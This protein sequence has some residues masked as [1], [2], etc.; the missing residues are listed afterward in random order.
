MSYILEAL[1]KSEQDRQGTAMPDLKTLQLEESVPEKERVLWPYYIVAMLGVG[2]GGFFA[3][4]SVYQEPTEANFVNAG[5]EMLAKETSVAEPVEETTLPNVE[6]GATNKKDSAPRFGKQAKPLKQKVA[7]AQKQIEPKVVFAK[8]PLDGSA[9]EPANK[10]SVIFSKKP[11]D[12]VV[13]I[14]ELPPEIRSE[15]P[16]ISFDGHV[17]SGKREQRSVMINGRKMQEGEMISA[18]LKLEKVTANGAV[19]EFKGYWFK[20]GALQDWAK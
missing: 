20:L 2:I 15:I 11:L 1:K 7:A 10:G 8:E 14:S 18:D 9:L 16:R 4:K 5:A 6:S 17:Y 3:W 19:F 12:G 13:N